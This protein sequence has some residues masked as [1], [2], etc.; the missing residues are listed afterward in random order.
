[1][2]NVKTSDLG[3]REIPVVIEGDIDLSNNIITEEKEIYVGIDFF[4]EDLRGFMPDKTRQQ[5]YVLHS[6]YVSADET[7]LVLPAGYKVSSLPQPLSL[8]YDDYT[9]N[10]S[11]TSQGNKI[12]FKKY[13]SFPNGRIRKSDFENW[14]AF[15]RK[16]S[17]FN[18][19]LL[20]IKKP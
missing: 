19:N 5:D 14:N 10:A 1:V 13:L 3:N 6:A 20:L 18:S 7:E 15:T 8:K 9:I 4:S 12:I 16:L 2:N 11:Y 17:D